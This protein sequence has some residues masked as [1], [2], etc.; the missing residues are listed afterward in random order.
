MCANKIK[1]F[2]AM[3]NS[4]SFISLYPETDAA[5]SSKNHLHLSFILFFKASYSHVLLRGQ[6]FPQLQGVPLIN[7]SQH[8]VIPYPLPMIGLEIGM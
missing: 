5:N 2:S 6:A 1:T 4:R 3:Q 8:V 7:L